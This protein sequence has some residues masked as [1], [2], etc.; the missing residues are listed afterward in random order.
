MDLDEKTRL[1]HLPKVRDYKIKSQALFNWDDE[2]SS[3]YE[4]TIVP[5]LHKNNNKKKVT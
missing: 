2:E 1:T 5:K 4:C 3:L